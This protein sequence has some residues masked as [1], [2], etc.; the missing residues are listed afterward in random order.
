[1]ASWSSRDDAAR[2]YATSRPREGY[3]G[4]MDPRTATRS[5]RVAQRART[6]GGTI[7][8]ADRITLDESDNMAF[9]A[10]LEPMTPAECVA[11]IQYDVFRCS[12]TEVAE[13]VRN[14]KRA[15]EAKDINALISLL[16]P[17]A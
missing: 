7:D 12:F 2:W 1:M 15:W 8:P 13:I 16:D 17:D 6:S 10:A 4:E 11:F 3:V 14:F 9:L 5:H